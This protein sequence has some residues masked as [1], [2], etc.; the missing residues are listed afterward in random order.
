MAMDTSF[1]ISATAP[2]AFTTQD[3]RTLSS[4]TTLEKKAVSDLCP[5]SVRAFSN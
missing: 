5:E 2:S 3:E 4:G 1:A